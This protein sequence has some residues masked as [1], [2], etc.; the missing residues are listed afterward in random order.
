LPDGLFSN[1]KSKLGYILE[2]LALEDVGI[3]WSTLLSFVTYILRTFGIIRGNLVYSSRFVFLY[4]EKS[5]NPGR[6]D[7]QDS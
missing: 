3:F 4:Q 7:V 1:Q 2:G 5:G 6:S